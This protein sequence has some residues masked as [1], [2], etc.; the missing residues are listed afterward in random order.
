MLLTVL[1]VLPGSWISLLA[2]VAILALLWWGLS[3]LPPPVGQLRW[4][5]YLIIILVIVYYLWTHFVH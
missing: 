5:G 4:L 3:F 1:A 2:L